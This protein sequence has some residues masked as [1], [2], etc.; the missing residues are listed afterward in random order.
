MGIPS[1][2]IGLYNELHFEK[3]HESDGLYTAF[4]M[5]HLYLQV[6]QK[7]KQKKLAIKCTGETAQ[8]LL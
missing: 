2:S 8:V 7:H 3:N 5:Q 1:S 4:A 6:K